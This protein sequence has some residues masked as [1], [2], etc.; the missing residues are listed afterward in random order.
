MPVSGTSC[1]P[2]SADR[3]GVTDD[4][5]LNGRLRLLQPRRGHRFGHDAV[6]LAAASPAAPGDHVV[7]LG[8]G[9]GAAGLALLARVTDINM[10]LVEIDANLAALAADNIAR[11]MFAARGRAVALD[12]AATPEQFADAG[13]AVGSCDLVLMNPPFNAAPLQPSPDAAR[14]KA[15]QAAP[16]TLRIWLTAAARLLRPAGIVSLIWRAEGLEDVLAG[17]AEAGF[18]AATVRPVHAAPG[19]R[20][21]RILVNAVK[22]SPDEPR[23]LPG[24]TLT[25]ADNR[26]SAEAEAILRGAMPLPILSERTAGRAIARA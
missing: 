20:P 9:V 14:R 4:A 26:P 12:V 10:M 25:T 19:G 8:S 24:L 11:N 13:L 22:G 21:I 23:L 5:I 3:E 16:D 6:L 15:H 17:L 7:E 2:M 1:G 18:G